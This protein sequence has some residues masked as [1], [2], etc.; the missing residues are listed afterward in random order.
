[1]D[2]FNHHVNSAKTS[3]LLTKLEE[4]RNQGASLIAQ[5]ECILSQSKELQRK[6]RLARYELADA[7]LGAEIAIDCSL[8]QRAT[9]DFPRLRRGAASAFCVKPQGTAGATYVVLGAGEALQ[10]VR[11]FE[12]SGSSQVECSTIDGRPVT[13]FELCML[14]VRHPIVVESGVEM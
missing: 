3:D 1:M 8:R 6:F 12:T 5:F 11:R 10:L 14:G 13:L 2:Q 9:R 7:L 4:V